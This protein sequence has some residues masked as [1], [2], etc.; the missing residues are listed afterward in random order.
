LS[1]SC[2]AWGSRSSA[3]AVNVS[4]WIRGAS[5]AAA[6]VHSEVDDVLQGL[7]DGGGDSS[8]PQAGDAKHHRIVRGNGDQRRDRGQRPG[9]RRD[10]VRISRFGV[11]PQHA[12][13]EEEAERGHAEA[14]PEQRQ[15]R[16][17]HDRHSAVSVDRHTVRGGRRR[18]GAPARPTPIPHRDRGRAA[19]Q[20]LGVE[21]ESQV[22]C[23]PGEKRE[24]VFEGQQ[25]DACH[26]TETLRRERVGW[27]RLPVEES[28]D[29]R[30]G[31]RPRGPR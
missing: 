17:G 31:H 21:Q 2:T 14:R 24:T 1:A 15:Q 20:R 7:G 23:G 5:T 25:R 19:A 3:L 16:L 4:A 10:R 30:R 11:E 6:R 8:R 22:G 26:V 28:Q 27:R 29:L 12:V 9:A 18:T 13:V